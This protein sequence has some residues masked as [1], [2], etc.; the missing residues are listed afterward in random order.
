MPEVNEAIVATS[1]STST[2]TPLPCA[3]A[4]VGVVTSLREGGKNS[5]RSSGFQRVL[6]HSTRGLRR[7]RAPRT[8][9]CGRVIREFVWMG[10]EPTPEAR[11][12]A[13]EQHDRIRSAPG[14]LTQRQQETVQ[15]HYVRSPQ[16][17]H[18]VSSSGRRAVRC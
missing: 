1:S 18:A 16:P 3:F 9:R 7:C 15:P 10:E 14:A 13:C 6:E 5:S 8:G 17:P 2:S 12:E 11:Q 4:A